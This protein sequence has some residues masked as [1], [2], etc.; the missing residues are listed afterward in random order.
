MFGIGLPEMIVILAVALIVVGPDKLP[1]LARSLAKGVLELKRTVNQ[2]KENLTE[3]DDVIS[4]VKQDLQQTTNDLKDQILGY[5]DDKTWQPDDQENS[6]SGIIDLK[7]VD[8]GTIPG[9]PPTTAEEAEEGEET[10]QSP[11]EEQP[12]TQTK[13]SND[14]DTPGAEKPA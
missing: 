11:G 10:A 13:R 5:G 9:P 4:S 2:V 12:A 8:R 6:D 1:D 3:D 14:E 7:P